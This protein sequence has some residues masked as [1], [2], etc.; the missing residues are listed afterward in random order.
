[1]IRASGKPADRAT[2]ALMGTCERRLTQ[3][4][5]REQ[6]RTDG[7]APEQRKAAFEKMGREAG[8]LMHT[9]FLAGCPDAA[10]LATIQEHARHT[11]APTTRAQRQ[12]AFDCI[13]SD[14]PRP[15]EQRWIDEGG[16]VGMGDERMRRVAQAL[17][18]AAAT[19]LSRLQQWA[20]LDKD[21]VFD[22]RYIA[23]IAHPWAVELS[24]DSVSWGVTADGHDSLERAVEHALSEAVE[25]ER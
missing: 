14:K 1:M 24:N 20:A 6:A 12:L 4:Q 22:I 11:N 2:D 10:P 18:D 13:W 16:G 21:R 15:N 9:S 25:E 7:T 3:E 23:A 17:A 8:E 19:P 5:L